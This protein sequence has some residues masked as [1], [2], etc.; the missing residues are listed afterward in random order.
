MAQIAGGE[1]GA[2]LEV[3]ATE[4]APLVEGAKGHVRT[5]RVAIIVL[6]V[7]IGIYLAVFLT[8]TLLRYA[9]FR[10]SNFDTGIFNQ[11]IWLLARF[12][13]AFSTI[14]GMNLFGDHFAPILFFLTPLYWLRGN[15]PALISVQTIAL[16]MGAIPIYFIAKDKLDSRWLPLG[17]A[18][19]YLLY[20]ALQ[21]VNLFDFHP[22]SIGL[23]FLLYAF[24]AI[25]RRKFAWFYVLCLGAAFC[26]EDMV[27][28]VLVLGVI[29]YFLYDKRAGLIVAVGSLVYFVVVVV[30]LIPHFAP[31][32]YQYSS[33]LGQ[34]GKTP[35]E[36]V[37]NFFLHP[38]RTFN[39]IATRMNVRYIFDLLLP[40]GFLCLLSPV[41]LLPALP[42]FAINIIS[43]FQPQHTIGFQYT[44]AIIP[45]VFIAAIFGLKKF[46]KW[47]EGGFR[48]KF[49]IGGVVFIVLACAIA[50]GFYFGPSPISA[51]FHKTAYN[52][53][54]HIRAIR[55]GLAL[56]PPDASVSAQLFMV[57]QLSS[58]QKIYMIPEPY[59]WLVPQLYRELQPASRKILFPNTYRMVDGGRSIAPQYA[60][61]DTGS[62]T[63][64]PKRDYDEL[65]LRLQRDAGYVP[66]YR[67]DGVLILKKK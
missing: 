40:V 23:V 16:A 21:Y 1:P 48:S 14:R 62:E 15:A 39:I 26:K 42:A 50:S 66:V 3:E 51:G 10:G 55:N 28:A 36:A 33:R 64:I 49:V 27:L 35:T 13:G 18:G 56:I 7:L 59:R 17:I 41:Y 25:E 57:A 53:D 34:F 44:A 8:L 2:E 58:R 63:G 45:F 61:L 60:V 38:G 6:L 54:K 19:A 11:V 31:A 43:D 22:E 12:K 47:T 9:N 29:V 5:D 4:A 67:R 46:K 24:W 20:P 37:K 52:S 30:V 65:A 32:G